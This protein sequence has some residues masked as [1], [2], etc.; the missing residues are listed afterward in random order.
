M[1]EVPVTNSKGEN[2]LILVI[3][4]EA[5]AERAITRRRDKAVFLRQKDKSVTLDREQMLALEYDKNQ[6]RYED[7]VDERSSIEDIDPEVMAR[8]KT[9][10]G[11]DVSDEQI[12]RSHGFMRN[13]HLTNAGI[14]LFA[15]YPP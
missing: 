15:E 7:E 11:T 13:G 5:S 6:R 4:I 8:Y 3:D 1:V 9:A 14:L 2:D 10:I 12:L